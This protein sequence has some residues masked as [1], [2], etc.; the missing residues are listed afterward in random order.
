[1]RVLDTR[2]VVDKAKTMKQARNHRTVGARLS[3][4]SYLCILRRNPSPLV[5]VKSD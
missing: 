5:E 2:L 1:M 4:W 3:H